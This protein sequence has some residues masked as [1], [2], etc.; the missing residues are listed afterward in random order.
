MSLELSGLDCG[1]SIVVLI[2][3][4]LLALGLTLF[5]VRAVR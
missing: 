4:S 3:F 2:K 5:H 1:E